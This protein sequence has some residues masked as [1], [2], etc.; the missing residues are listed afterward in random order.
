MVPMRAFV[1]VLL[2]TICAVAQEPKTD[3]SA[4]DLYQLGLNAL[5][6]AGPSNDV[7][8]GIDLIR[9]AAER[10]HV[11]AETAIGYVNDVGFNVPAD[12]QEAAGW[13]EK[14]AKQGDTLAAWSLGRL[15]FLGAVGSKVDGEKWL[16]QAADAGDPFGSYLLAL[17]IKDRD[18]TK[19]VRYFEKAAQRGLPFAQFNLGTMLREGLGVPV[20]NIHAYVWLLLSLQAGVQDAA[21]PVQRLEAELGS[22]KVEKEKSAARDLQATVLRSRN[23]HG[24]TGWGGELAALPTPPPLEL[25]RFCR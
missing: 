9:Q 23:G 17:S 12:A 14:A 7:Q 16:A 13:Y 24:C 22:T 20:D 18:R 5:N 2:L 4:A 1:P 6:G 15:Y 10:G 19:A 21:D 11:P 25:Q 3:V 8:K